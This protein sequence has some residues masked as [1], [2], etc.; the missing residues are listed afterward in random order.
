MASKPLCPPHWIRGQQSW[1]ESEVR[2]NRASVLICVFVAALVALPVSALGGGNSTGAEK[3]WTILMYWDAENSLEFSTE[4]AMSTWEAALPSNADVNI[5][6]LVDLLSVEGVWIWE[7]VD[8][9]R[10]MVEEWPELN[11][12]DPEVLEMFV[13]YAM[14]EFPS[15]KRM[16]ALPDHGYSWSGMRQGGTR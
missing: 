10:Q 6:A 9:E 5:I 13:E 3:D 7:I 15:E 2:L 1:G 16:L 12:S 14:L 8:G 4:F 11:T